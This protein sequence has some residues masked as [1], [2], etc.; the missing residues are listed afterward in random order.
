MRLIGLTGGIATGKSTVSAALVASGVPVVDCDKIARE[1][2]KKG[3]WV[4]LF[5]D[6]EPRRSQR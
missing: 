6:I 4:G 1:A 2:T 3:K 5:I